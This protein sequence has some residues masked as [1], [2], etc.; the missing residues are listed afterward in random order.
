MRRAT[1]FFRLLAAFYFAGASIASGSVL[2][3]QETIDTGQAGATNMNCNLQSATV[4]SIL[5]NRGV[6]FRYVPSSAVTTAA[7]AAGQIVT[8]QGT[9]SYDAVIHLAA[10]LNVT[11]L[12]SAT[13]NPYQFLSG[14]TWP[15]KPQLWFIYPSSGSYT[16]NTASDTTGWADFYAS[17]Q[18]VNGCIYDTG[19]P[20]AWKSLYGTI[21]P[22]ISP[23][24]RPTGVWRTILGYGVTSASS[25]SQ[26]NKTNYQVKNAD[27]LLTRA[28]D[29]DSSIVV[30]RGRYANDPAGQVLCYPGKDGIQDI[31][32]V[33]VALAMLDSITAITS[34]GGKVF[35][36][37][38]MTSRK[39][40]LAIASANRYGN[41]SA[42]NLTEGGGIYCPG[43]T[44]DR[45]NFSAGADS[46]ASLRDVR[47][48]PV[49]FTWLVDPESLT[50]TNGALMMM[51]LKR[52]G[53]A[54][55]G[56][57]PISGTVTGTTTR[58]SAAGRC[59]DPIGILRRRSIFPT[60]AS[61]TSP[62]CTSD[63]GSV[64]CAIK[65]GFAAL[66]SFAPGRV[67]HVLAAS[68]FDWTPQEWTVAGAGTMAS[69][70]L[71]GGEDSLRAAL[72]SAKVR[73][74][75]FSPT[76]TGANVG[77]SWSADS[78]ALTGGSAPAG[79][80]PTQRMLDVKW[81][82]NHIGE[83]ALLGAR[84]EPYSVS[85]TWFQ[86][87]HSGIGNEWLAG[88]EIGKYFLFDAGTYYR[89][90]FNVGT[91]VFATQAGMLGGPRGNP[92][93]QRPGWWQI[94]WLTHGFNA[95]NAHLPRWSDGTVK[96]LDEWD[97][98]EN[99]KP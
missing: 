63:S 37:R 16:Q 10:S 81:G 36:N 45:T 73:A 13:Y 58:A 57:Q 51:I 3:I 29:P 69:G 27:S 82:G 84:W 2:V 8:S 47:G 68:K 24:T 72:F 41:P 95:A 77:L 21:K 99:V 4:L 5:R 80:S 28:V 66:E 17:G 61:V 53:A 60:T 96:T 40:G 33:K 56:L 78:G 88:D 7:V 20:W 48:N 14:S 97:Y 54:H 76:A 52:N 23:A 6:T 34:A 75:L 87:S 12:A 30:Y 39:H 19:S 89:H 50:T 11:P 65:N 70:N 35:D 32:S 67:D 74:I 91:R 25:G 90:T 55:F 15:S 9:E 92:W 38:A 44:C 85:W 83:I 49:K 43:D 1:W 18:A 86:E 42:Y 94:K 46:M 98:I 22:G 64:Q 26:A 62:A 71:S 31:A 79:W 59:I 93:P